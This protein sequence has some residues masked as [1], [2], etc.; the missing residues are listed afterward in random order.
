MRIS[1]ITDEISADPET[2]IE[3][4]TSWGVREFELRGVGSARVPRLSAFEKDRLRE[5]L[6]R[7]DARLI[8]I[9]PGLFKCPFPPPSRDRSPLHS[10]DEELHDRWRTARDVVAYHREELLPLSVQFAKDFGASLIIA[11]SFERDGT[12][13]VPRDEILNVFR[14]GA[15]MA[16]QNHLRLAMEVEAGFWADRGSTAARIM[17]SV[18]HPALGINWDPANAYQAGDTPYPD[19]YGAVRR[20]VRHVHFKDVERYSGDGYRYVTEGDIDWA[21]QIEALGRDGYD[22][23]VSIET[24]MQPKVHSARLM[25][26][27]LRELIA[28]RE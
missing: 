3:L 11:F 18:N 16:E 26:E 8:A 21:G 22:G 13:E 19:G 12:E 9:S 4:G 1:I 25:T 14:E 10:L 5:I 6:S 24:H 23:H 28:G 2:A 7:F 15:Q 17:E 27:R 20:H